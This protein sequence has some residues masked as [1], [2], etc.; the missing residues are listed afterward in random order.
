MRQWER[1]TLRCSIWVVRQKLGDRCKAHESMDFCQKNDDPWKYRMS[2][3][4]V[5]LPVEL[6]FALHSIHHLQMGVVLQ[7]RRLDRNSCQ[8]MCRVVRVDNPLDMLKVS[9]GLSEMLDGQE[10]EMLMAS[11]ELLQDTGW[12]IG[13]A[14]RFHSLGGKVNGNLFASQEGDLG[15]RVERLSLFRSSLLASHFWHYPRRPL[16]AVAS[17]TSDTLLSQS[18][19]LQPRGSNVCR[20]TAP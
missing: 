12:R 9:S 6:R 13:V 16:L 7:S 2:A 18:L 10:C 1:C 15:C 19:C 14:Q 5:A 11:A 3:S 8:L 4:F 20:I 17:P